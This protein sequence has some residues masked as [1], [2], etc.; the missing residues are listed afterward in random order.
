MTTPEY[1]INDRPLFIVDGLLTSEECQEFIQL[2]NTQELKGVDSGMALYDRHVMVSDEWAAKLY[3]RII[4][5]F[6]QRL[7]GHIYVNNH[8]RFSKYNPGGY[9]HMHTDG[10]NT[11]AKGGRSY[12][13]INIFL[14]DDFEGG[15][16]SFYSDSGEHMI[17]AKPHPGR[18]AI[19]DR[20][21]SHKGN[22]VVKGTKYLFRTDMM[23]PPHLEA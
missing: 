16:T 13:T 20:G 19:F 14:N 15:E 17:T 12:T 6:P 22:Q 7:R 2:V 9:F 10:I 5:F 21:I 3:K 8:F 1:R 23:M 11:D 18:G 4:H